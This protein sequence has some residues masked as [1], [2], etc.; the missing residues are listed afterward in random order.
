MGISGKLLRKYSVF[1]QDRVQ[2]DICLFNQI[3]DTKRYQVKCHETV[4]FYEN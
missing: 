3:S 4:F 2:R 1:N